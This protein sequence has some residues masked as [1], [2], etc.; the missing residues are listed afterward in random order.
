[1]KVTNKEKDRS[2]TETKAIGG[3]PVRHLQIEDPSNMTH[4]TTPQ[5]DNPVPTIVIDG[6]LMQQK[7]T[8]FAEFELRIEELQVRN[9]GAD[10]ANSREKSTSIRRRMKKKDKTIAQEEK[11]AA[12]KDSQCTM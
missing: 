5:K 4:G 6:D 9:K 7:E 2:L 10:Q 3:G 1:M 11:N 12:S 8:T